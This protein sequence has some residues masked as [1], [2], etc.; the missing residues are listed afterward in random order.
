MKRFAI[1]LDMRWLFLVI[2]VGWIIA[3]IVVA[4][5]G[6]W[7]KVAWGLAYVVGFGLLQFVII[8]RGVPRLLRHVQSPES[9]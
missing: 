3:T 9:N 6:E 1:A 4:F 5:Q 8:P 2:L 7:G